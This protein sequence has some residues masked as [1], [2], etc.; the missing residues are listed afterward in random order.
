[1]DN[2]AL[3]AVDAVFDKLG[4]PAVYINAA[5]EETEIKVLPFRPDVIEGF[6]V[7]RVQAES[8]VFEIRKSEITA[9]ATGERI[10]LDNIT[11]TIQAV[12]S[13]DADRLVWLLEC[14]V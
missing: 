12:S 2:P 8:A 11:Y 10:V 14:Y 5:E 13:P 6:G 7:T 3:L 4:R 9:P 1:M